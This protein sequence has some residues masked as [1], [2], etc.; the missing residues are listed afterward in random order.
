VKAIIKK[1][2]HAWV[3]LYFFIYAPWFLYLEK[4]ITVDYQ[5]VKIKLDDYI[6]F[7]EWFVIPYYVWFAFIAV[8]LVYL[9]LNDTKEFY[10]STAFLFLG[11]TICLIIYTIWPNG[12]NLRPNLDELGR[13]NILIDV[14]RNL[15]SNDTETNVCPSIHVFNSIGTCIAVFHTS[16]LR[17]KKWITIPT[18]ILTILI[19]MSTA[20]LKQHSIFD[21][22]SAALLASVMYLL[23]YVPANVKLRI[24]KKERLKQLQN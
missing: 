14:I 24:Q 12:Q 21:G 18:L 7:N 10:R 9:F 16:K 5:P 15:Y 19:C 1:Y 23:V 6:A 3:F 17:N 11:M 20:F 4:T 2:K 8:V 22:I 13:D